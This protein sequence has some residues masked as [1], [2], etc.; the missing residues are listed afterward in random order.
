MS[1]QSQRKVLN[2]FSAATFI[3]IYR[4]LDFFCRI[5]IKFGIKKLDFELQVTSEDLNLCCLPES[6]ALDLQRFCANPF[7]DTVIFRLIILI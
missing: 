3:F 2:N 1:F 4:G 6:C 5:C 7:F